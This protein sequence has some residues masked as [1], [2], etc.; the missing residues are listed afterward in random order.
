MSLDAPA[1]P[2]PTVLWSVPE[3]QRQGRPLLVL[4]H[5]YGANEADLFGLADQLPEEFVVASVRAPLAMGP[6]FTWFPLTG[7]LDYSFDAVK[8]ATEYVLDWLDGVREE[9]SSVSLLGFSMGMAMATSMWR[10]R[11]QDFAAIVGLSGF[12][13]EGGTDWFRDAELD[14]STPFFWGRDPQDPVIPR[15]RIDFT[16][17]WLLGKAR[18]TKV[19]YSGV[20]HGISPQEVGHVAEFLGFEVLSPQR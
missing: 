20:W 12:A 15:D 9:F 17:A 14:G 3:D 13:V 6:G 5:G 10:R 18:A 4:L 19:Q 8:D 7:S 11:P 1:F 16:A 2:E